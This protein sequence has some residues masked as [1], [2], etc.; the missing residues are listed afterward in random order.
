MVGRISNR[1]MM[2][3][4]PI[5]EIEFFDVWGIDFMGSFSNSFGNQYILIVVDYMSKWVEII[6]SKTN[7]NKVVIKF[8]KENIFSYFRT[9][10]AILSN[11]GT[12]SRNRSFKALMQK[13]AITY[14]LS[15]PYHPQT[16]EQIEVFNRRIKLILDKT[17]NQN[18]KDWSTKLVDDL[19]A[20]RITFKTILG[21]SPYRLVFGKA[22]HLPVEF[23]HRAL[24]AIKQLNFYLDKAGDLQKLQIFKLEKN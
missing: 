5:L 15:T 23:E 7:D 1:N 12:Y 21:M 2:P 18:R 9:P 13:Y 24:W 22:C 11:N 3:L 20:H 8:L 4:N 6:P 19:W 16:S 17:L 10:R 14:K